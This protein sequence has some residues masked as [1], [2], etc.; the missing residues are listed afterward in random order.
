MPRKSPT[1][2]AA[3]AVA[4]SL[5]ITPE[6]RAKLGRVAADHERLLADVVREALKTYVEHAPKRASAEDEP[7]F[8]S[9]RE[10]GARRAAYTDPE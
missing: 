1:A 8:R 4:L 3:P 5:R 9:V 2:A 6:L 7:A 10:P